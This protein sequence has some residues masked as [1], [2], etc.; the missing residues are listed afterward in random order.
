MK[1]A[2]KCP[3]RSRFSVGTRVRVRQGTLDPDYPVLPLGGWAGAIVEV[4]AGAAPYLVRWNRK[5]LAKADPVYRHL[6]VEDDRSFEEMWLDERDL[7]PDAGGPL[8]IESPGRL[9]SLSNDSG[10][11]RSRTHRMRV[12]GPLAGVSE[13]E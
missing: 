3:P 2:I 10:H 1:P 12:Q 8:A 13:Q 5:T 11:S 7:E 9:S 6:C 4:A